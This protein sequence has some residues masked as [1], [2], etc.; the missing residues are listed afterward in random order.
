MVSQED[1][2]KIAHLADIG[3]T[4]KELDEFTDQCTQILTYFEMLDSLNQMKNPDRD[5]HTILREDIVTP[6]ISQ[7]DALMNANEKEDGYFKAPRV[8]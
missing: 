5:R 2:R 1:V 6:S 4:D 7:A 8:M 3:I